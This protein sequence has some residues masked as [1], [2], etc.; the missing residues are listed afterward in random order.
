MAPPSFLLPEY[1]E[2]QLIRRKCHK[3]GAYTTASRWMTKL[4]FAFTVPQQC[5][6]QTFDTILR[7]I[8]PYL[9]DDDLSTSPPIS[10]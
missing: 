3:I 6:Q 4:N 7:D 5:D 10:L 2:R 9:G 1:I 8:Y